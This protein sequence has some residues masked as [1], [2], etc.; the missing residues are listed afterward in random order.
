MADPACRA[1]LDRLTRR[2]LAGWDPV[3]IS[4]KALEQKAE[5]ALIGSWQREVVPA[6]YSTRPGQPC[7]L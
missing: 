7:V 3:A 6:E 2:L 4:A 1:L 5:A